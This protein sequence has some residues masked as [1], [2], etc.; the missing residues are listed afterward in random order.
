MDYF[1]S[2]VIGSVLTLTFLLMVL[3]ISDASARQGCIDGSRVEDCEK[4]WMPVMEKR[5]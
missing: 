1:L 3:G 2:G 4:R 5:G